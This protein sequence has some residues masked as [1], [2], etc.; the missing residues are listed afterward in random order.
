LEPLE[1]LAEIE[2]ITDRIREVGRERL[3]LIE[4]F[5]REL[6]DLI[7]DFENTN[8]T[9]R[10]YVNLTKRLERIARRVEKA[11]GENS[12]DYTEQFDKA[13]TALKK[14]RFEAATKELD[15]IAVL[16]LVS[17]QRRLFEEYKKSYALLL[18][19]C[20][21]IEAQI[22][23]Q[24]AY[25][26]SLKNVDI[27]LFDEFILLKDKIGAYNERVGT[28]LET[29]FKTA[30]LQDVLKISLDASYHPELGFPRPQN[31]EDAKKLVSFVVSEGFESIL[32]NQFIEYA[33]YSDNK[34]SHFVRDPL[35]FRQIL[36]TNIVWLEALN[37]V[38]RRGTLNISIDDAGVSLAAKIPR[39][40]G[41]LSKLRA[42]VDL[43]T[44]LREVQ[45]F[46]S[47]GQYEKVRAAGL[48]EREHLSTVQQRTHVDELNTLRNT[49]AILAGKLKE[50][51]EP[52]VVEQDL[53]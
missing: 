7:R 6:R 38:K 25:Y 28:F 2:A 5:N 42:S 16:G 23:K 52:R 27:G 35:I 48:I 11:H 53:D 4:R 46:V 18:A 22:G 13:L 19:R 32:L 26:E 20:N 39:I 43:L 31:Y 45:K 8:D 34:L 51:P 21:D 41:F 17:E 50:L 36:E 30:S 37:D 14:R 49:G 3:E 40:I 24:S 33:R 44:A 29:F 10:V 15:R 9:F 1:V 12:L 47:S